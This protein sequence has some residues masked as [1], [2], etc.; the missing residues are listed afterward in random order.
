LTSDMLTKK[1]GVFVSIKKSGKLRGCIG[2]IVATR[3]NIAEEIIYNAVS[4][5]T[6]D[7]RFKPIEEDELEKLLFSVDVL[8]ESFPVK[9]LK[10]PDVKKYGVIVKS[11]RK[12]GLLLPDI[13]GINTLQEQIEI[14]LEKAGIRANELYTIECFKVERHK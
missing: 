2:T 6:E 5:G 9:A 8:S 12:T 13:E 3:K 11:G 4:A 14:A 1:A 10:D 7:T